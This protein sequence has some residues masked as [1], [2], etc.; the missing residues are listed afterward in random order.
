[1]HDTVFSLEM[2]FSLIAHADCGVY[3]GTSKW[4]APFY[5][6][7]VWT[8]SP[9]YLITMYKLELKTDVQRNA[10]TQMAFEYRLISTLGLDSDGKL[11]RYLWFGVVIVIV[12]ILLLEDHKWFL[13]VPA[14][15]FW[16]KQHLHWQRDLC[17]LPC[18]STADEWGCVCW[19]R[20]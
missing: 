16:K 4:E 7:L 17:C 2:K 5:I 20:L 15:L 9:C 11:F 12:S 19:G 18:A 10:E 14:E 8:N 1:M 3:F 6:L 13:F